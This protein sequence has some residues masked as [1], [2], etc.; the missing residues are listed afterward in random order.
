MRDRDAP[1]R[2]RRAVNEA[3]RCQGLHVYKKI[4][5]LLTAM[6]RDAPR[7]V[8]YKSGLNNF[9]RATPVN[10]LTSWVGR[11]TVFVTR[12]VAIIQMED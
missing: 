10:R 1:S 9:V 5:R 12:A 6:S 2:Y 7:R 11:P 3:F 8:I 4:E